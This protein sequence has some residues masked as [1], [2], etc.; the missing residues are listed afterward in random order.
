VGVLV[1]VA[2]PALADNFTYKQYSASSEDWKRGF[3]FA[4]AQHQTTINSGEG[5]PFNNSRISTMPVLSENYI[6]T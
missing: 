6:R 3:V 2:K 5:P 1:F 4:V